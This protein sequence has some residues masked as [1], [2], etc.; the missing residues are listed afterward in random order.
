M[1]GAAALKTAEFMASRIGEFGTPSAY[2]HHAVGWERAMDTP[3]K[4]TGRVR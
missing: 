3:S 1:N 2:N 4:F